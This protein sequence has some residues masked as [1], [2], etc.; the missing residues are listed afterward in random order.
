MFLAMNRLSCIVLAFLGVVV[1]GCAKVDVFSTYTRDTT[2]AV[3]GPITIGEDIGLTLKVTEI[4][5]TGRRLQVV[6]LGD[7]EEYIAWRGVGDYIDFHPSL[8]NRGIQILDIGEDTVVVRR[9]F[10]AFHREWRYIGIPRPR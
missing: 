5:N 1:L 9:Y 3:S 8:S 6:V 10:S 4:D 2:A 7:D